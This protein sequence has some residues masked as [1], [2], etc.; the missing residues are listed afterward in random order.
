[1]LNFIK[2]LIHAKVMLGI[3]QEFGF[4]KPNIIYRVYIRFDKEL[5][6]WVIEQK[7]KR[8]IIKPIL[9]MRDQMNFK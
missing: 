8:E 5:R 2:L 1:M 6:N 9:G 7:L 3:E 4:G